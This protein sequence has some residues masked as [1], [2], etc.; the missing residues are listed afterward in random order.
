MKSIL[1]SDRSGMLEFVYPEK[2]INQLVD[3]ARLDRN[4]YNSQ[5]I[6]KNI[7]S[8]ADTEYIFSTWG[9]PVFTE[10]EI[11]RFFPNL[12]AVFYAAGS[13]QHFARPFLNSGVKVFS[14]SSVSVR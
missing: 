8:F 13:V 11:K 9:M 14:A 10:E 12:R 3:D 5:D 7:E 1:L 4:F 2:I 6:R